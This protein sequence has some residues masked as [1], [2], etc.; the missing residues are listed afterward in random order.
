MKQ[1][2]P[3]KKNISLLHKH[4]KSVWRKCAYLYC[5]MVNGQI[6]TPSS[7]HEIKIDVLTEKKQ[8]VMN[9]LVKAK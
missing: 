6:T 1:E 2:Y 3:Q 4:P 5:D 7:S 8:R 9:K